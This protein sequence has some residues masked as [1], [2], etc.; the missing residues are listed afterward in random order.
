MDSCHVRSGFLSAHVSHTNLLSS[1]LNYTRNIPVTRTR[2]NARLFGEQT[3]GHFGDPR[4]NDQKPKT[5]AQF[6]G[7]R[8]HYT[9][10]LTTNTALLPIFTC[11]T[12][13]EIISYY[14]RLQGDKKR[15]TKIHSMAKPSKLPPPPPPTSISS[16]YSFLM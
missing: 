4:K 5:K 1:R 15:R 12:T 6:A 7:P 14:L 9:C 16:L 10:R 2:A 13:L 3:R 11:C 8:L